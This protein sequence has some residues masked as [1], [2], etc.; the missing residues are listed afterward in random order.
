MHN[1]SIKGWF[2]RLTPEVINE[3]NRK[4]EEA[5]E[6]EY[7]AFKEAFDKNM[8]Y[9][10]G[11]PLKTISPERPCVHWLIR[12]CKF[13]KKDFSQIIKDFDYFQINAYLRWVANQ[14][15]F[16]RNI[17]D[18][19]EE[20]DPSKLIEITIKYKHIEW[21]FSCSLEDY[22]GHKSMYANYPHYHFQMRISGQQFINF[23]DFHIPFSEED[24]FKLAMIHDIGAIES[25]G[26]GG[27]GLEQGFSI[28]PEDIINYSSVTDNDEDGVY[29][30]ST[31][32]HFKERI[33]GEEINK[34]FEESKRTGKTMTQFISEFGGDVQSII[35][36][37]E[38][39]PKIAK[40]SGRG[41]S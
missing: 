19:Q 37:H 38:S 36:P 35:S 18:L 12:M 27:V 6:K 39:L 29:H 33:S 13:R 3:V 34:L 40:R 16:M 23:R 21:S 1:E 22:K 30:I 10:C 31:L 14:D 17:N 28:N 11:A 7:K 32:A 9:I 4:E 20:K 26:P 2:N 24:K 15:K 41:K 8:C 25:Y 5:S